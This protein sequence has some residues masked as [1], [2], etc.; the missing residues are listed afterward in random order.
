M[1]QIPTWIKVVCG[2]LSVLG[3]F[4]GC[5]LYVTPGTFIKDVDFSS[6]GTRFLA[7]M[8]G[9]RQIA[10][11]GIIGYSVLRRS[12]AMLQIALIAYCVMNIQDAAIGFWRHDPG[13]ITGAS[14]VCILTGV[15]AF[16]LRA[17]ESAQQA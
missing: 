6:S 9:A 12:A 17:P 8:W 13:L 10:M 14:F 5:S 2:L 15:M 4:V 3:I 1:K 7:Y 16:L 11:A